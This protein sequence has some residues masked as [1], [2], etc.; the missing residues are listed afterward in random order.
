MTETEFTCQCGCQKAWIGHD[1]E[2]KECPD[3][4]RTYHGHEIY[5]KKRGTQRILAFT[6]Q[7]P[8]TKGEYYYKSSRNGKVKEV[9]VEYGTCWTMEQRL[10]KWYTPLY[11][12]QPSKGY[13]A[14]R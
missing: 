11:F 9:K 13:W 7:P 6:S 12:P 10:D 3:C 4:K 5:D 8:D 1:K 14:K 2:L